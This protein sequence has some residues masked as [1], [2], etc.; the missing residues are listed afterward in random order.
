MIIIGEW[1]VK[2]KYDWNINKTSPRGSGG[3]RAA[4]VDSDAHV[5]RGAIAARGTSIDHVA[6][7]AHVAHDALVDFHD[8]RDD[9]DHVVVLHNWFL[10]Y[11]RYRL[12]LAG[13]NPKLH[14][15]FEESSKNQTT[16]RQDNASKSNVSEI[17]TYLARFG[18]IIVLSLRVH[19]LLHHRILSI[20]WYHTSMR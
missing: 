11:H 14:M 19:W 4:S 2:I 5:A 16:Y 17:R 1:I 13:H 8:D 3:V 6:S 18:V 7:V 12:K 20:L 10:H 9:D 15:M